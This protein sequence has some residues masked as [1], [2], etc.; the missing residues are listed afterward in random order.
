MEMTHLPKDT[1]EQWLLSQIAIY[2]KAEHQGK[3]KGLPD[4]KET[5]KTGGGRTKRRR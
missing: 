2:S 1:Y 3:R 5:E 4:E